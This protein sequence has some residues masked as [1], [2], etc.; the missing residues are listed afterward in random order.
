MTSLL[1]AWNATPELIK[2]LLALALLGLL[3]LSAFFFGQLIGLLIYQ[4]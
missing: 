3:C 1:K 4:N 2:P